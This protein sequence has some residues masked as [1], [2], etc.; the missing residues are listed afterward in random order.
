MRTRSRFLWLPRPKRRTPAPY[1]LLGATALGFVGPVMSQTGTID[2]SALPPIQPRR[3]SAAPADMALL[4]ATRINGR[5]VGFQATQMQQGSLR[6]ARST[7]LALGIKDAAVGPASGA[8]DPWIPLSNL[9]GMQVEYNATTQN[10]VLQLPFNQLNWASTQ[11]QTRDGLPVA[12]NATPGIA[13][14][15]DLYATQSGGARNLSAMTELR[16][17]NANG[18]FSN[19]LLSQ[20]ASGTYQQDGSSA[21][22][23][24]QIRLDTS[25]TMSWPEVMLSLRIGDVLSSTQPWSRSTRMGGIQLARNFGLQPYRTTSPVPALMGTSALPSD[26]ALY[27]N[28]VQQYQGR[29]PSGPFNINTAPGITGTGAAQVVLTDVMGRQ[30]TLQYSFY[31]STSLL[32]KGLSD[33]S[34]E[35]GF[36]RKSYG[37]RSFDYGSDPVASGSWSYGLSDTL[38]LQSH[39]EV[40]AKLA[41]AGGGASWQI[42]SI[43]V[44][45]AAA[46]A[47]QYDGT[48]GQLLQL[49]HQWSSQRF[50]TSL[51]GTIANKD[52]RDAASLYDTI[53]QRAAGRAIVGYNHPTL[54][55]FSTG[56]VYLHNFDQAAQRYA[57]FGWSKPLGR[58]A[59]VNVNVNHNLDD[60][61]Q[62]SA[63]VVFNWLLG[64]NI[65][66]GVMVGKQND[67]ATMN[68]FASQS[69]PSSG[70][71]GWSTNVQHG[72][73]TSAQARLDYLGQNF[74]A[75]ATVASSS[76]T[77]STAAGFSGALVGMGGHVF[78][79][80]RLYDGFALVST[81]G[82]PNVPIKREN[83]LIGRTDS[84]GMLLVTQLG[85]YRNNKISIDPMRLPGQLRVPAP[86]QLVVPTDRAGTMVTFAI[87]RIQSASVILH[88]S[89]GQAM[90]LGSVA[91][92]IQ[93]PNMPAGAPPRNT[94][95]LVGFDGVTY[96]ENLPSSSTVEVRTPEGQLC[97]VDLTY[98]DTP[99]GQVPMM[100]PV[101]CTPR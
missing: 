9:P 10:L 73:S 61:R 56:L 80:R 47:S 6:M 86:D 28:G 35:L 55:S 74:E 77:T 43:G 70:G 37:D 85:A 23:T 88:D 46:A 59:Y 19:T 18:V 40:T 24:R 71:W 69:R 78:A 89:S 76:G 52:Y 84:D 100:G 58:Q 94:A 60:R 81:N 26:I 33:W 75:N 25:Y 30:T 48:S 12:S 27:I 16:A 4:L 1:L 22:K 98:P 8:D 54:G 82:I 91:R 31:G 44:F 41:N 13:L 51:Q 79:S 7:L 17:F 101:R 29:I 36:V 68:A 87:D 90:P 21:S 72:D 2:A 45:S 64:T 3:A 5:D 38:T 96:F 11:V 66:S 39:G 32:A 14:N 34:A 62:S 63:Q 50:N 95:S 93:A 20:Y 42:G 49:G 67:H 65:N 53:R 57:T 83:N 99:P 92:L 97:R 15:Y